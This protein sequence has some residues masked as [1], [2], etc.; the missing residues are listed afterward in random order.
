MTKKQ[1]KPTQ[2]MTQ[3][4]FKELWK[5]L[6]ESDRRFFRSMI[7][8]Q[9]A[10]GVKD[11]HYRLPPPELEKRL[12]RYDRHTLF[13]ILADCVGLL[14]CAPAM[15]HV[16]DAHRRRANPEQRPVDA[17]SRRHGTRNRARA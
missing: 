17:S 4:E 1:P 13:S 9:D 8:I 14:T 7:I 16:K 6:P 10:L 12:V 15:Q 3:K 5:T 11:L 2:P